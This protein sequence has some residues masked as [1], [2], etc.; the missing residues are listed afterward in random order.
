[1]AK[2][3]SNPTVTG[4]GSIPAA[5][6]I[7]GTT[8]DT[9]ATLLTRLIITGDQL[10]RK[11]LYIGDSLYSAGELRKVVNF[12]PNGDIQIDEAFTTPLVA[13]IVAKVLNCS[14]KSF[15]VLN[16]GGADGVVDGDPLEDG[17]GVEFENILKGLDA[18]A[19]DAGVINFKITTTKR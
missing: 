3:T 18:V 11:S 16:L 5:V 7:A 9:H 10:N 6:T 15:A 8:L 17:L 14:L 19:Y 1:M 12:Y 4:K 13:H 2:D